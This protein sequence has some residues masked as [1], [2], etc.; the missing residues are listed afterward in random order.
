ME[1]TSKW[2]V[3]RKSDRPRVVCQVASVDTNSRPNDASADSDVLVE[4]M[5]H[6]LPT[7]AISPPK[8]TPIQSDYELLIQRLLGSVQPVQPMVQERSSITDIEVLLQSML[9][10][11]SVA[12]DKVHPPADRREPTDFFR[13]ERRTLQL[14]CVLIWMRHFRSCH[15]VGG[16]IGWTMNLCCGRPQRGPPVIKLETSTDPG[17]GVSLPD[18]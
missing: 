17:R 12:E 8:A 7:P 9:P 3:V 11:A 15:R 13:A 5:R 10:V 1:D 16:R 14:H 6:L 18:K 2:E 4:L